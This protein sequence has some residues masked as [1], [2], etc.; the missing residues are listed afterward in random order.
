MYFNVRMKNDTE[1]QYIAVMK[2]Q[3]QDVV[4]DV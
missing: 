2:Y 1:I 4:H 3:I